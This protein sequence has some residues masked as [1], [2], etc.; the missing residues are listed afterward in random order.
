[1][2]RIPDEL[3][4]RLKREV[5]LKA[6]VEAAGV[7]L[8]RRGKEWVGLCPLHAEKTPSFFVNPAKATFHCFGCDRGGSVID[9]RMAT[10]RLTFR[11][12]VESLMAEHLPGVAV[13]V[14]A[15]EPA[16]QRLADEQIDELLLLPDAALAR[17]VADFY[18]RKAKEESK[19]REYLAARGLAHPD[20]LDAFH[21]GYADRTLGLTLPEKPTK[22]GAAIRGRL[23]NLGLLRKESGHEHLSGRLTVPLWSLEGQVVQMYGRALKA[24]ASGGVVKHLYL[25]GARDGVINLSAFRDSDELIL[26]EAPLDAMTFWCAGFKNVTT[27]FGTNG[28]TSALHEALLMHG[29]RRLLIAYDRDDAGDTAARA[30]ADRL[31]AEGIECFRVAFPKGLDAN[32]YARKVKPA[33]RSLDLVLRHAE[34]MGGGPG[35]SVS[36]PAAAAGDIAGE[37]VADPPATGD[38]EDLATPPPAAAVEDLAVAASPAASSSAASS[39]SAA[40]ATVTAAPAVPAATEAS[41]PLPGSLLPTP[42][43]LDLPVTVREH[44]VVIALGDRRYRVRGLDKNLSYDTLRIN[45]FASRGEGFHVDTLDLISERQRK[46]FWQQAACE[47][48]IE[49]RVAKADLGKVFLKLEQLQEEQI[50]KALEPKE[51]KVSLSPEDRAAAEALLSSA[52]LAGE[53]LADFT[54]CGVVG[55]ETNKLLGYLAAISR[56]LERPLAVMVQSSSAAGKSALMEAVLAFVPEEERVSYSAMTG[57]SL[58]YMG[59]NDLRH[60]VLAIAEEE[61][62][63]R[64]SYALKL[65]QSEGKLS[66][67]STGKDPASGRLVTHEYHVEGP[68]A[69]LFTTTAIDLDEELLNRCLVL[70]VD[71]TREQT[72]AIHEMQRERETLEGQLAVRRRETIRRRHQNAQRLLEPLMVVNPYAP[73]LSFP[74]SCTRTRR[75]H[76]KYLSLIRSVALLHQRQRPRLSKLE[77]GREVPFIEATLGDIALANHLAHEVLGRTLDELPPQ[78]RRLLLH[79]EQLVA[80]ESERQGLAREDLR[81]TRRWLRERTGWGDT[82]LKIH[83]SRLVDLEYLVAHGGGHTQ[84]HLYELL[85]DG[86]GKDGSPFLPGLIDLSA[87]GY[88]GNRS[89]LSPNRSGQNE[90]R[91]G[92]NGNR[93]ALGRP[94]VGGW[95]G[96]GRIGDRSLSSETSTENRPLAPKNASGEAE[97]KASSNGKIRRS[98]TTELHA[99]A[100]EPELEP[101]PALVPAGAGDGEGRD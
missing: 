55:E 48:G 94:L 32:E 1:M 78:T 67:A 69:I 9:F 82:Q 49:P 14:P 70:T 22:R 63:A 76:E 54:R 39:S 2:A 85:Y 27:S 52:D 71:E 45:L 40:A 89:G 7:K 59:E 46:A 88:D 29:T 83:L 65:L 42:P 56:K 74:D 13:E 33:E 100:G 98:R 92:Q 53:I 51:T 66:I 11:E 12:A 38:I 77:D 68:V 81:F 50:R 80:E 24:D 34:W 47:L 21:L 18:H 101:G 58:F 57:Q 30:L 41:V 99:A 90:N 6:V 20:L 84:R 79:L 72:R 23:A 73:K 17:W 87:F 16:V 97:K 95:S 31:L 8:E 91:S 10:A 62:A 44:E 28:F 75:D 25:E 36:V 93:S 37:L 5:D 43:R 61:G 35:P 26:C 96:G 15:V 60:K 86:S 19:P 3:I 4:A 64:A